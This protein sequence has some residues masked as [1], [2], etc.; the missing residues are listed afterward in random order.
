MEFPK[1]FLSKRVPS[2]NV[3]GW[4]VHSLIT[5]IFFPQVYW[6]TFEIENCITSDILDQG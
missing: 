1:H 3:C 6:D 4:S 2:T 5:Q